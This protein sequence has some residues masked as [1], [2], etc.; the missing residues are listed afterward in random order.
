MKNL[1]CIVGPSGSGKDT[2]ADILCQRN[3]EW[4]KVISKT[5]R[6]KRY[7][8]E[9][10]HVFAKENEYLFEES[11]GNV[12]AHTFFNGAHYW[13]TKQMVDESTLYIIDLQGLIELKENYK[14]RPVKAIA[15]SLSAGEAMKRMKARGDSNEAIASRLSN[16]EMVFRGIEKACDVTIHCDIATAAD[17]ADI[18][19]NTI[20]LYEQLSI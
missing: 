3:P 2:V 16:D 6:P 5:T 13:A 7:P 4:K 10:T 17:V 8:E 19:E 12:V 20:K 11:N 9:K 15:L 18:A 1:W 14:D